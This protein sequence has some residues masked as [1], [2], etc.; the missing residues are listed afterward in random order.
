MSHEIKTKIFEQLTKF[1]LNWKNALTEKAIN[2]LFNFKENPD[3]KSFTY[4]LDSELFTF[5]TGL[6]ANYLI[7]RTD[8]DFNKLEQLTEQ[9]IKVIPKFYYAYIDEEGLPPREI[10]ED[11]Y[12]IP[13]KWMFKTNFYN[14]DK[15]S[16]ILSNLP[17]SVYS[18]I[19]SEIIKIKLSEPNK[20]PKLSL[21]KRLTSLF[22]KRGVK[23]EFYSA[24][25]NFIT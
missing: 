25:D 19:A 16:P 6:N 1:D 15:F 7:I 18:S 4:L 3:K 21:K 22:E 24:Y 9:I 11:T 14:I 5:R 13:I 2:P 20:I 23:I 10:T 12:N 17:S 8:R